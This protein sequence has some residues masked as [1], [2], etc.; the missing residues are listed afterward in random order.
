MCFCVWS[1]TAVKLANIQE[2]SA[3]KY[4]ESVHKLIAG[5]KP[6]S[7]S[8]ASECFLR[9][10]LGFDIP[11]SKKCV[12]ESFCLYAYTV[13]PKKKLAV[14]CKRSLLNSG[15]L[16]FASKFSVDFVVHQWQHS[17]SVV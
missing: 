4:D 16:L 13:F 15:I 6:L 11:P 7:S 12:A 9:Q 17:V 8:R 14:F 3:D 10:S 5:S 2:I 1:G